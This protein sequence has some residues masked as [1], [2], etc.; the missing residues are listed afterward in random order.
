MM[1]FSNNTVSFCI[2]ILSVMLFIAIIRTIQLKKTICKINK[3]M[4]EAIPDIYYHL[5]AE[6]KRLD[7]FGKDVTQ[8]F[9]DSKYSVNFSKTNNDE[10]RNQINKIVADMASKY[11]FFDNR[12]NE[13]K[14]S[15]KIT[16]DAIF[17]SETAIKKY[18]QKELDEIR[19]VVE[20]LKE[21]DAI[22]EKLKVLEL[23][24]DVLKESNST[25]AKTV[26]LDFMNEFK[27]S[28]DNFIKKNSQ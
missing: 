24:F 28:C 16:S 15:V 6:S 5:N 27:K 4:N 18:F 12:L 17:L 3:E 8:S 9:I 10:I 21:I 25:I 13:I 2:V 11:N 7:D 1:P 20:K 22:N 26:M 19:N 23:S 14:N